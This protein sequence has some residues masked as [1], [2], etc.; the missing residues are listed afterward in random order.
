[1]GNR[2]PIWLAHIFQMAWFNH[3]L[4]NTQEF[5]APKNRLQASLEFSHLRVLIITGDQAGYATDLGE[6]KR[7]G[8]EGSDGN[9]FQICVS[10]RL[11]HQDQPTSTCCENGPMNQWD[12]FSG[13]VMYFLLKI[14]RYQYII[15]YIYSYMICLFFFQPTIAHRIHKPG[16]FTYTWSVDFYSKKMCICKYA[17]HTDTWILLCISYE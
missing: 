11:L 2:F 5:S 4:I 6:L 12:Y 3:Q 9:W 14:E 16:I 15:I 1:M 7:V 13:D 17:I 8:C 10:I